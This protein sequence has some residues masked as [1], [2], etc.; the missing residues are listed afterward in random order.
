MSVPDPCSPSVLTAST[1]SYLVESPEEPDLSRSSPTHSKLGPSSLPAPQVSIRTT[2]RR[3]AVVELVARLRALRGDQIK[4]ALYTRGGDSRCQFDLTLLVRHRWLDRL[5]RR[6][7]NDPAV[8]LLSRKSV[9]GNRLMRERW[10]KAEFRRQM[11]RLGSLSHL[12]AVNDVRVRA[13]RACRDLSWSLDLWQRPEEL[14]P[15]LGERTRLIPD[16]Y[17]TI[18]R[19]VD[20][21]RKTAGFFLELQRS[22][23]SGAA[24]ETKLRRYAELYYSGTY[25]RSFPTRALR[26]LVVFTSELTMPADAR[27]T[28]ALKQAERLGITLARFASLD[29]VCTLEPVAMLRSPIWRRPDATAPLALFDR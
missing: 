22:L 2:P 14:A 21:Q 1:P 11:F 7:V 28:R 8:Y 9:A 10:G 16:A 15:L 26:V 5:P 13:E 18:S 3:L 24:L 23:K 27:V 6:S 4:V 29:D 25:W 12:L 19:E 17:F 20:G